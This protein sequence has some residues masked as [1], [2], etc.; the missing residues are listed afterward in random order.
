MELRHLR[1]FVAV[2][3]ARSFTRAAAELHV[4]QPS[5]SVQVRQ[6]ED[7]VGVTLIDRSRRAIALTEAGEVMLAEARRLLAQLDAAVLLVQRTGR[8]AV[9]RLAVGFVPSASNAALPPI[10][11]RFR[12]AHPDVELRLNELAPDALVRDTHEGRLDV[13]FL[14]L[15]F[16]DATLAQSVVS[17]EPFVVALSE[18][19]VLAEHPAIAM[20]ELAD[21]PWVL[22]ARHG[23]PGLHGRVLA[24][25]RAAGFN[26][27]A[28][29]DD[30]WLVQTMVGLVAAGGG[31]AL[32]PRSAEAL[33]RRGVAYRPLRD[34]HEEVELAAVWRRE[35]AAPVLRAFIQSLQ[36]GHD[37][38]HPTSLREWQDATGRRA[39]DVR[40]GRP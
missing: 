6:L 19:H 30:V 18:D 26:P 16:A 12:D 8:G 34:A 5:L 9:G 40:R 20:A 24:L 17:C 22:P 36:L 2:A 21:E 25:C 38:P 10:L 4:A 31:V 23:M 13:S 15:P 28:A 14:Y 33:G 1:Y 7:E 29:Q 32:V 11:R 39:A 35:N 37:L 27:R 3:E